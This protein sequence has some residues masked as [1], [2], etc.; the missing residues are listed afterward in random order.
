[1]RHSTNGKGKAG[2]FQ[3]AEYSAAMRN[4]EAAIRLFRRGK[5]KRAVE[6][7]TKLTSCP[8][9]EVA[10]RARI[11]LRLC[12]QRTDQEKASPRNAEEQYLRGVAALNT[13]DLDAAIE[14]LAKADK[15]APKREHVRYALAAAHSLRGQNE[16]AM[17]YLTS[18]I[19]LRPANRVRVHHDE[20]FQGLANDPRFQQLLNPLS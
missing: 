18:A 2:S 9:S 8:L 11:H 20:D 10:D 3:G 7:F 5:Y 14:H 13:R 15:L 17:K 4:F 1:M 19:E 6:V 16:L 12:Q